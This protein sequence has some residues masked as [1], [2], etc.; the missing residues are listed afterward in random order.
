[1]I[2]AARYEGEHADADVG[3]WGFARIVESWAVTARSK[4][5]KVEAEWLDYASDVSDTVY[6]LTGKATKFWPSDIICIVGVAKE[7]PCI[8]GFSQFTIPEDFNPMLVINRD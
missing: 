1:M 3:E 4:R 8:D 7:I 6:A 2:V 5:R